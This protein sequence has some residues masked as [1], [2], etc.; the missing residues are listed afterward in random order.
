[1]PTLI[2]KTDNGNF[3]D[4]STWGVAETGTGALQ[5]DSSASTQ[6]TTSY[7]YSPTFTI[8]NGSVIEGVL[9]Y[10]NRLTNG[11][12][13]WVALSDDN[14][15][16]ATRETQINVTDFGDAIGTNTPT[17]VFVRFSSTLTGDGG[18]D[19]RLG[20]KYGTTGNMTVLRSSTAAD[21]ARIFR[22]STTAAPGAGDN[23]Y[24][25][26]ERTGPGTGNDINVVMNN[27]ASTD[28][29]AMN[30]GRGGTLTWETAGSTAYYL[31]L[32]GMF[33]IWINGTVNIGTVATPIPSTSSAEI[34]F[35]C[36][37]NQDFYMDLKGYCT[38]NIQGPSIAT[39]F[40]LMTSDAAAGAT[41][42]QVASTSGWSAGDT[43]AFPCTARTTPSSQYET[44]TI[45]SV[46]SATQVTLSSALTNAHSG[47][48]P[49]AAV[50]GNLSRKVKIHGTN[51]TG[52]SRILIGNTSC[53]VDIDYAEFYY[54]GTAFV[55]GI[56][57]SGPSCTVSVNG[58][59]IHT[60]STNTSC[61]FMRTT[62]SGSTTFTWNVVYDTH[63][64]AITC[65]VGAN[66][67]TVSDCAFLGQSGAAGN[68]YVDFLGG[69]NNLS[70]NRLYI[71]GGA[72]TNNS[73]C[74]F[75]IAGACNSL[76]D[77]RIAASNTATA[78]S[79]GINSNITISNFIVVLNATGLR[80]HGTNYTID[81]LVV[82]GN[83]NLGIFFA[84]TTTHLNYRAANILIKNFTISAMPSN[85]QAVGIQS[86][87]ASNQA[88]LVTNN[89]VFEDGE[90]GTASS[91]PSWSGSTAHSTADIQVQ[92]F[93]DFKFYNVSMG[94]STEVTGQSSLEGGIISSQKHD[95]TAGNHKTW[96][97][98]GTI[99]IDTTI[100]DTTPSER[101]TPNNATS[102]L[103]SG[104][105]LVA[106][107]SGGAV[108][109]SVKVR[110]SVV[111]DGAAYNGNQPRLIVKKNVAA[112]ITVDTVLA[113][114]TNA[115]NGAW[116]TLSGTSPTVTD[117]AV[118]EFVID[119]DGTTGWIN[120]DSFTSP[121]Q[122]TT[123]DMKHW[124]NGLPYSGVIPS[125]GGAA[126]IFVLDDE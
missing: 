59:T 82:A 27:T 38:L 100:Y 122:P 34:L 68:C 49:A 23:L 20:I 37:S 117:D 9:I 118:L 125:G 66:N 119:C 126:P 19:Y 97:T 67:F 63:G 16:T 35:D 4:A 105:H 81:G 91:Y 124:R 17:W 93:L 99:S 123:G 71:F 74:S 22:T 3:T 18:S 50:V 107:D 42:I 21:W 73:T 92:A 10:V 61:G 56:H 108:T 109:P 64:P 94:S 41:V 11:G 32:S 58:S 114:A 44:R 6:P 116:E 55:G 60:A 57:Q 52:K 45:L 53:T 112:G 84:S 26:G 85:S 88:W 15:V 8:T 96:K 86:P 62:T 87:T 98:Y 83:T 47:T 51:N 78:A 1:M 13:L 28:F 89:V 104:C 103:E 33:N 72:S 120:V 110:K 76:S 80:L 46:D 90:I 36:V 24:I 115:A 77:I 102:K 29:G 12:T 75:Q 30:V 2:A 65:N 95:R 54:M 101:L 48:M 70:L 43:L 31:R 111:G 121:S 69:G 25:F 79:I 5:T 14:G 113:T 7:V 106:V 40:S 39:P